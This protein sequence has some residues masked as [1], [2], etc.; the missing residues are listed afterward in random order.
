MQVM[1][2]VR[3]KVPPSKS[4]EFEKSYASIRESQ[5]PPALSQSFLLKDRNQEG[6]YQIATVWESLEI[7]MKYKKA[8]KKGKQMPK[9]V[10]LFQS[11][12]IKPKIESYE[13]RFRLR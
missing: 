11:V 4:K 6:V 2:V 3:G 5:L 10:E 1:S 13:I 8:W 7:L 12:G 9:A